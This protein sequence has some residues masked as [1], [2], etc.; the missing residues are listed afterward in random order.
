ME[1]LGRRV[2]ER[3]F[4]ARTEGGGEMEFIQDQDPSP[5]PTDE[6][7]IEDD[8]DGA[9]PIKVSEK[10]GWT[11]R[12]TRVCRAAGMI[13]KA[14]PGFVWERQQRR[15]VMIS[16]LADKVQHWNEL[17]QQRIEELQRKQAARWSSNAADDDD[18]M[19]I[20]GDDGRQSESSDEDDD[21]D[22]QVKALRARRRSLRALLQSSQQMSP[23]SPRRRRRRADW[24]H[25]R[26]RLHI[27]PGYTVLVVDTNV[28]LTDLAQSLR[29]SRVGSGQWS[30]RS[31]SSPN[32]MAW[33]RIRHRL[34]RPPRRL[35]DSSPRAFARTAHRSRSRHPRVTTCRAPSSYAA[36][37]LTSTKMR[38]RGSATW[39][40]S[41]SVLPFGSLSTGLTG[42]RFCLARPTAMSWL[43]N[44]VAAS[45]YSHSTATVSF[46]YPS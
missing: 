38:A 43:M 30:Y 33:C 8:S 12:W 5:H 22:D 16:P 15:W 39:T 35:C 32:S 31:L 41:F 11:R 21:E 40:I 14:V 46:P 10:A 24:G 19:D 17:E 45:C 4:W 9:N 2:Y 37:K 42:L 26:R 36:N 28:L 18:D 29:W 13:G 6:G 1:W 44:Q 3:G 20:D 27:V 34:V 7:I 25:S 23:L